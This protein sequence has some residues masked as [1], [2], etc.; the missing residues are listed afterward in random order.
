[1]TKISMSLCF[2]SVLSKSEVTTIRVVKSLSPGWY[3]AVQISEAISVAD[4][5]ALYP[6]LILQMFDG[7]STAADET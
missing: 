2:F 3:A 6:S 5:T 7:H 4:P 1:M